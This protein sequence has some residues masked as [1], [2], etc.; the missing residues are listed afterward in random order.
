MGREHSRGAEAM[1][2]DLDEE[3]HAQWR[4]RG[5]IVLFEPGDLDMLV[6][7][8]PIDR[9]LE[10]IN[11]ESDPPW[12]DGPDV[13]RAG[14]LSAIAEGRHERRPYSSDLL[15]ACRKDWT[16]RRHEARIAFLVAK[17]SSDPI[18]VEIDQYG[19][20]GVDDGMHRLYAAVVRGDDSIAI[21]IG[22]FIDY[23]P[24]AIGVLCDTGQ[25]A[26]AAE[27]VVPAL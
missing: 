13:T 5:G 16:S 1:T 14:I 12:H 8:V 15:S 27:S 4:D 9:I 26:E 19:G 20:I 22:G 23:A 21:Q 7:H 6:G 24:E 10:I 17:P 2:E 3:T 18:A 11:P 25:I